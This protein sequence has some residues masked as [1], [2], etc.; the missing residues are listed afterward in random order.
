MPRIDGEE[1]LRELRR[2]RPDVQV[3]ICSGYSEEDLEKRFVGKGVAGLIPKSYDHE[4]LTAKFTQALE[5]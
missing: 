4:S 1:V 5:E 3:I 2:I